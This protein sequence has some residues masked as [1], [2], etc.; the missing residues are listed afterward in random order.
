MHINLMAGLIAISL[1]APAFAENLF[2]ERAAQEFDVAEKLV[3]R[4]S[5]YRDAIHLSCAVINAP[6]SRLYPAYITSLEPV[7]DDVIGDYMNIIFETADLSRKAWVLLE[8]PEGD[9]S[10]S[11]RILT[12]RLS[13]RTGK[14]MMR[15]NSKNGA[16]YQYCWEHSQQ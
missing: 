5:Q 6:T 2:F 10:T 1:G 16:P 11:D 8:N 4:G 13:T 15:L 14:L 9:L 3:V 7:S 12:L